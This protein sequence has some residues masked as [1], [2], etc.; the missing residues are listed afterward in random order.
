MQCRHTP[1]PPPPPLCPPRQA[2]SVAAPHLAVG[3]AVILLP[4]PLH[5]VDISMGT[6]REC[7]HN[8]SSRRRLSPPVG[9]SRSSPDHSDSQ[10][11]Q[12][13]YGY[14]GRRP[15]TAGCS[16]MFPML[17]LL[18]LLRRCWGWGSRRWRRWHWRYTQRSPQHDVPGYRIGMAVRLVVQPCHV[19]LQL[20]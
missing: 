4:H 13:A 1:P 11:R 8:D 18:L 5:L 16:C 10:P 15:R 6:K 7:R 14:G 3:K 17:L 12:A 20:Q 19:S 2:R 9:K